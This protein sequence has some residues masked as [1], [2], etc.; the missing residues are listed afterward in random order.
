M[1]F[2][3]LLF[4]ADPA[5]AEVVSQALAGIGVAAQHCAE[6]GE[7]LHQA[8]QELF[9]IAII[10][11]DFQPEAGRVLAV[12][13]QRK[14]A[15]RPLALAVVSEDG[16]VPRALQ[17]GAN[18][19]LRKPVLLTQAKDTLRTARDLLRARQESAT[20]SPTR[21][22]NAAALP[23]S[24]TG[25]EANLRA[26]EFLIVPTS[27]PGGEFITETEIPT[28]LDESTAIP[29]DPLRELEPVA[30]TVQTPEAPEEPPRDSDEKT[31][32]LEWYLKKRG[33]RGFQAPTPAGTGTAAG[34]A[35]APESP[36]PELVGYEHPPSASTTSFQIA[37]V[38]PS[39]PSETRSP[40]AADATPVQPLFRQPS[41]EPVEVEE[42]SQE[43]GRVGFHLGGGT[44]TA[45]VIVGALA[46][47][48][49]PQAP[50]HGK[51]LSAS[52]KAQ[53]ALHAWLNPQPVAPAQA[54]TTHENFAQAGDEYKLPVAENI[55]DATTDPSQIKV[56]PV[57]DPTAKKTTD[58]NSPAAGEQGSPDA[59]TTAGDQAQPSATQM[60]E[61]PLQPGSS[62]NPPSGTGSG[63]SAA[64]SPPQPVVA[65]VTTPTVPAPRTMIPAPSQPRYTPA[66]NPSAANGGVSIP[67]SLKSQMA[68]MTPDASGNKPVEAALPT[69]EPVSVPESAERGLLAQQ[70]PI[71]YPAGINGQQGTV[72]L[73]VLIGRDGTVQDAKFLQ[74]S[75]V[76]ARAAIEG[77]K[78]W[79]FKPYVMNGRPV[80]VQTTLTVGFKPGS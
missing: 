74:G 59:A 57:I 58:A 38:S 26:G 68:S 22:N 2:R 70:A 51:V 69:I 49:A 6:A 37:S 56:E 9:Q 4:T 75:L 39:Q 41:E 78:Q 76:F 44:I 72:A 42:T 63:T 30:A 65:A 33:G 64:T 62:A 20:H 53:R 12:A 25:T 73:Q 50:W 13:R 54:P 35:P 79:R 36:K 52:S 11:W 80:S 77:V 21:T 10:D 45:A 47:A 27:A 43:H 60:Q 61:N 28:L 17:A 7:A 3:C 16:D 31:R 34:V 55:P 48:L 15:E 14:P 29:V 67:S 5:A 46:V 19:I 23:A 40:K 1:E 71:A 24:V 18:S 8:E 66:S 32:G